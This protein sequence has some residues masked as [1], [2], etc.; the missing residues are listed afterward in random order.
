MRTVLET[1][2]I[3]GELRNIEGLDKE[4]SVQLEV[5]QHVDGCRFAPR[6]LKSAAGSDSESTGLPFLVGLEQKKCSTLG[7]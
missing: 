6:P 4:S 1:N 5:L 2:A 7:Y 3:P